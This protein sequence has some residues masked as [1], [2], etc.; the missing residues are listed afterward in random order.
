MNRMNCRVSALS[1]SER[2]TVTLWLLGLA[3]MLLPLGGLGVD[4]GRSFSSRRA[5]S[6]AADA[7][8]LAGS[9]AIDMDVY[10]ANGAVVIDPLAAT[11][12]ARRSIVD[13]LDSDDLR[14]FA[15][16]SDATSV[17]VEVEGVVDLTL[18]RLVRGAE[19]FTVRV[20][21][22]ARPVLRD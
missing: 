19:P 15:V 5:L 4:L 13:Q 6:A 11:Q 12:R 8:A 22:T 18:L 2:G 9:G 20:S 3:L 10:R 21:S 1:R 16:R 7:A 17:T 14:R